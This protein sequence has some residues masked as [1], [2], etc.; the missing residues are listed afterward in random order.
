YQ[1]VDPKRN[2][3]PSSGALMV[4]SG[5]AAGCTGPRPVVVYAHGTS[6]DRNF[7][8]AELTA[9]DDAEG[10]LLAAVFAA[11]GYITVA[12]NYLGYASS[13]LG[14]HPYLIADQQANEMV[15]VLTAARTALPTADAPNSSDGG[16]LFVTGYSEGGYVA[17]AT[18]RAMENAG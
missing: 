7:D 6:T 12:P 10:D 5:T 2:I 8:I 17:M 14:Y 3:V 16:K 4:P 13:T 18:Q 11:Q 15:D 9:A 1:T